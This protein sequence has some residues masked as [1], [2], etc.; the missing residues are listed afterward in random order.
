MDDD[1][2]DCGCGDASEV[3][4][5]TLILAAMLAWTVFVVSLIVGALLYAHGKGVDDLKAELA[6]LQLGTQ[7][8]GNNVGSLWPH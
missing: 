3:C 6:A 7:E 4:A 5:C 1:D 8:P 2:F